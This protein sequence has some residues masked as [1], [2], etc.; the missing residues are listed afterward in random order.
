[1]MKAYVDG[2]DRRGFLKH[3]AFATLGLAAIRVGLP[4]E[5]APNQH[6]MLIVGE[7]TVFLSHL[8][9]FH[10]G[11]PR[12]PAAVDASGTE[13]ISPHRFQVILEATFKA[14]G[15][16]S[17]VYAKDRQAHPSTKIYTLRPNKLFVL[18]RA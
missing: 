17:G 16:V 11:D 8:P 3:G 18:T 1:M 7:Q 2:V 9:M 10:S 14:Q 4:A 15:D 13:F 5:D 12:D 6:N